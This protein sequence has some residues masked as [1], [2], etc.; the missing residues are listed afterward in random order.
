MTR[1]NARNDTHLPL[2]GISCELGGCIGRGSVGPEILGLRD[3]EE[4]RG[5]GVSWMLGEVVAEAARFIEGRENHLEGLERKL[6][7]GDGEAGRGVERS[8]VVEGELGSFVRLMEEWD[9]GKPRSRRLAI[10]RKGS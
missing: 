5:L 9:W 2:I 8:V 10:S 1:S 3:D 7:K 4:L 6:E